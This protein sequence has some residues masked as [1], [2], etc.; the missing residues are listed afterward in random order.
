MLTTISSNTRSHRKFWLI[1]SVN[2]KRT[3]QH[4]AVP[5]HGARKFAAACASR[6]EALGFGHSLPVSRS[7]TT[8]V[9]VGFSP[10]TEAKNTIRRRGATA[11]RSKGQWRSIVA[12]RRVITTLPIRGLKSTATITASLREASAEIQLRALEFGLFPS[13]CHPPDVQPSL[14]RRHA[15]IGA[16]IVD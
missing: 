1:W 14:P 16:A 9:A 15:R 3:I 5:R 4:E 8:M 11:E 13:R 2:P 12:S 7:E 10:R 6:S